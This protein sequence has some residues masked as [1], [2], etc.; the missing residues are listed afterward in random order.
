MSKETISSE[1]LGREK[2][3]NRWIYKFANLKNPKDLTKPMKVAVFEP[4]VPE[5]K[6]G[7]EYE[8]EVENVPMKDNPTSFYH[9]L[10]RKQNGEYNIHLA[11][12]CKPEPN[13]GTPEPVKKPEQATQNAQKTEQ[14][15]RQI[16]D[17][18]DSLEIGT[19][20]KGGAIKIYGDFSKPDEFKAKIQKAK[21]VKEEAQK[22][23]G[24]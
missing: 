5:L 17:N 15:T 1:F 8:F 4:N 10:T 23:L 19:P 6:E 16:N 9:N 21:E 2:G 22:T 3:N 7:E 18:P 12:I 11:D 20:S 14:I 13:L 24:V